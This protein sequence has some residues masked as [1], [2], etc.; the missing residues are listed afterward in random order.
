MSI[1]MSAEQLEQILARLVTVSTANNNARHGSFAEC[2]AQYD[3]N[4]RNDIVENFINTTTIYKDIQNISDADAI[5]GLPLLLRGTALSWWKGVENGVK[6]WNDAVGL[7]RKSF[8]PVKPA[9]RIYSELFEDKQSQNETTDAF[10]CRKRLLLSQLPEPKHS[11]TIELDLVYGLLHI[12]IRREV[13]RENIK[14][15][16]DLLTKSRASEHLLAEKRD[17]PKQK[18]ETTRQPRPSSSTSTAERCSFCNYRGH[19]VNECRKK[20]KQN[21]ESTN[22]RQT[23]QNEGKPTTISCYGCNAPGVFRS[24]CPT[25]SKV[26]KP[27]NDHM[28]FYSINPKLGR[29]IPI[30]QI[31]VCGYLG[32]A[33]LDTAARTSVASSSLYKHLVHHKHKFTSIMADVTLADGSSRHQ[34]VLSTN[35]NIEIGGRTKNVKFITLPEAVDNKTLLGIDFLEDAALILHVPQ[36]SW[37]FADQAQNW[38]RY[39]LAMSRP[40]QLTHTNMKI[41]H[42]AATDQTG[43]IKGL[44]AATQTSPSLTSMNAQNSLSGVEPLNRNSSKGNTLKRS[45]HQQTISDMKIPSPRSWPQFMS[46]IFV[47]FADPQLKLVSPLAKTPQCTQQ[48]SSTTPETAR[49][50][51]IA[52]PH[53]PQQHSHVQR[54]QATTSNADGTEISVPVRATELTPTRTTSGG[55]IK[56]P[57]SKEIRQILQSMKQH[58]LI[59]PLPKTPSVQMDICSIS[60]SLRLDEGIELT[61]TEREKLNDTLKANIHT[62]AENGCPTDMAEHHI[63]TGTERPIAM[64]PYRLAPAKRAILKTEI[65]KMLEDEII[66][67]SESPWASPVVLVPKKDG[68]TRVC[69]DYRQLNA[70]TVPDRYPLPRIDDLL[71]DAKSSAVMSTIDLHA[72]YWQIKVHESDQEKTAFI[73]PMGTYQFK[74]MPFGLRNAPATFQ[75]LIDRF[76]HKLPNISILAYLDDII[77]RSNTVAEHCNDLNN[78]FGCLQKFKLRANRSKCRFAC[79]SIKYL[80]HIITTHG[81]KADPEKIEAI[82][83]RPSP[84]NIKQL[85]SFLQTCSWYRRFIPQFAH[86][87]QPLSR[88]TRKNIKWQWNNEEQHAFEHLKHL[89]T[90]SPILQQADD[91]KAFVIKTDAS[92]Y[93]I[94]AVLVQGESADEHPVE[95]AS[96][97]LTSAEINY[98]TIEREALAVVW[99]TE[100]FRGYIDGGEVTVVSDHQ[101]LKWLMSL[102]SPSGRLAR[103]ALKLQPFNLKI[104]YTP[105]RS[106]LVADTLSR[107]PCGNHSEYSCSICT[108]AV[109]LPR[110]GG[111]SIRDEQLKDAEIKLIIDALEDPVQDDVGNRLASRGYLLNHGI[112]YRYSPDSDSEQTQLVIPQQERIQILRAYHDD[113]TAGHYGID[114]TTARITALYHWPTMRKDIRKFIQQC[115]A[116][117]RYK[118]TNLKPAGLFQGSATHHR[119]EIIAIDL[120]GPLPRTPDGF[121]HIFIIEDIAS[122]WVELFALSEAT[123]MNCATLLLN[124]I[125]LRYGI[126]RRIISDHGSQFISAVIQ[127]LTYCLN[128]RHTLTPVYHPQANPVERKNRDL[129]TQLAIYVE[130]DHTAWK[131]KLPAIRFAM[132]TAKNQSTGYTAAYLT[133]GREL[134][135]PEEIQHDLREIVHSENFIPE[136]SPQLLRLA[137]TL[138]EAKENTEAM[139]NRNRTQFDPKRRADP[140]YNPGDKVLVTT[141]AQ[142]NAAKQFTAKLAP[143]R[144]GPYIILKQHGPAS[145]AVAH[146]S[147]PS[148]P[149]GT[150][151][152]S[153]LS[154]YHDNDED[155]TVPVMPIR[156][157]GRPSKQNQVGSPLSETERSGRSNFNSTERSGST[158]NHQSPERSG[159]SN[160]TT[161]ER[162]GSTCNHQLS[163]RSGRSNLQ[164]S[165]SKYQQPSNQPQESKR[166]PRRSE[167]LNKFTS[168]T[169]TPIQV[170][171][172]EPRR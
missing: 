162:S 47:E 64:P 169:E 75:R 164:T 136:I 145:Y 152:T 124:E 76:R 26:T 156:R 49:Q 15:F 51:S 100:K 59:S 93:A 48:Q 54:Q 159:R 62:F 83:N 111:K 133:F 106:N 140:G 71:Q 88:L 33:Y 27:I 105:G 55:K 92:G 87:T 77:I 63:N 17:F 46:S 35:V 23:Q 127:K 107:P 95:Y 113:P 70:I 58:T 130:G 99:A 41:Y 32:T 61:P 22:A 9:Y 103:W 29:D 119:F 141:H 96:R 154:R 114:R 171:G 163:E 8:A 97:L 40:N 135:A 139:Q 91:S 79:S 42:N 157:R 118:N 1:Q 160:F 98:S 11:E 90:T 85:L 161:P 144:D 142:S 68:T 129:K 126:P 81:I 131:E 43:K 5:K 155:S 18:P 50:R 128:I 86:V 149:V 31:K 138:Q 125:I 147:V 72:G 28:E 150:F 45:A 108:M 66:T 20:Q 65:N 84:I 53:I 153:M 172:T 122:R 94:G 78:V 7:I 134:R 168:S 89:L 3:G 19:T 12:N 137:N 74:R 6:T 69:I 25:C 151:H 10:I 16:D 102:K 165:D 52:G 38:F 143:K 73:T 80:G 60:V 158:N 120:F 4:R 39:D 44:V 2:T 21:A 14:T 67:E 170:S 24:N 56:T 166:P 110:K 112:L 104:L 167:R 148:I 121:Q 82:I 57:Q 34:P 117:Q 146:P 116:C 101:P 109:D 36:R 115:T 123:A 132:N 13:L 30:V 37:C